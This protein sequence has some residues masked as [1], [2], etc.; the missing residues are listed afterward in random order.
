MSCLLGIDLGTSSVKAVIVTDQ[1]EI[2]GIG[3][4]EYPILI[5][6][7]N[8][9]E[10]DPEAW[11]R[12][13]L[14]AVHQALQKA[15]RPDIIGVG[16]SGQMHGGV[17]IGKDLRPLRP[18]IIWADQRS[19]NLVPEIE[20]KVGKDILGSQCGTAPAAGF[21]ISTLV[22][23]QRNEPQTIDR[24]F[25][26]L[27][28]KDY[29]RL[30]MTD[31][32]LT[33]ETDAAATGLFDIGQR[34]WSNA[35]IDLL[36]LP[37]AIFPAT[38]LS[39]LKVGEITS[40][41]ANELGLRAGTPVVAG[42]ADQ[43]AQAVGNGLLDPPLGSVTVG[44]GGQVFA[45]LS[46]PL[47]DRELRMHTFCHAPKDRWYLLGAMLSAG[48]AL[49]WVRSLLG[50]D[51]LSYQELDALASPILPGSDGLV[52]L[53]YLV[54]ERSPIM[55]PHAKAGFVGLTLAHRPGHLVRAVLE[56]VSFALRQIVETMIGCGAT[57]D[58]L[59]AS[60][61][62]LSSS[63][64]RQ[65]LADV[66]CRPLCRGVDVHA[67]ERGGVGAAMMAG[68]GAGLFANYD[69]I[70]KLAP[71]FDSITAPDPQGAELYNASYHQFINLYP[72]LKDWYR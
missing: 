68:I 50:K 12:A 22:W 31:S 64:W 39:H 53:P 3:S 32:A 60:G 38:I 59:V 63:F 41:A 65:M 51:S 25:T 5:P 42:S 10:Q 17:L 16:F 61:N 19:A 56:G 4:S 62:G 18:A 9:A 72:R 58:R 35:V 26:F 47:F 29:V 43:P 70:R 57:L 20:T 33:D 46:E 14:S 11:W 21:M 44:T 37:K 71:S 48:M 45:P 36:G 24:A 30:K 27:L 40:W 66:L 52:F 2:R 6:S 13:T 8:F 49:R 55:D 69:E 7:P 34:T 54:G 28:P 23:L 1:G 67:A 15:D